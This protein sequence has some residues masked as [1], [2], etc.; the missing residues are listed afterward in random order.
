MTR[1]QLFL[2]GVALGLFALGFAAG[3]FFNGSESGSHSTTSSA[4]QPVSGATTKIDA[5]KNGE[6]AGDRS[7]HVPDARATEE[8]RAQFLTALEEPNTITRL[9]RVMDFFATLDATTWPAAY[10]AM[11][12]ET[13]QTGR[14]HDLE[15]RL[16]LQ[17]GGEVG[18][19]EAMRLLGQKKEG[20][21]ARSLALTG[22]AAV[23]FAAARAW[24]AAL[25]DGPE[26]QKY[27][28]DLVDGAVMRD[29]A[30]AGSLLA[31]LPQDARANF[32]ENLME[33]TIQHG[34]F[35]AATTLLDQIRASA[36]KDDLEYTSGLF[37]TLAERVLRSNW[38]AKTPQAACAW[39]AAHGTAS[40]LQ[41][42][43]LS[44]AAGDWARVDPEGAIGWVD[45]LT[46]RAE[47]NAMTFAVQGVVT[48][49][50]KK[51]APAV[52]TWLNANTGHAQYDRVAWSY[53]QQLVRTDPA[54]AAQWRDTIKDP[55][56]AKSI[57]VILDE[58]K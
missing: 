32:A 4:K 41:P 10:E 19:V 42:D 9:Q 29:P 21:L 43:L 56:L 55:D 11:T 16:M 1:N 35:T 2:P 8:V 47:A 30:Q 53:A 20:Q 52:G 5:G 25:P 37:G 26:K 7:A 54:A 27:F 45:S 57:P 50:G 44:H 31:T 46:G 58:G 23:D 15:W 13:V 24:V 3:S 18:G 40:D 14:T 36:A 38:L 17:R 28:G 51:D 39:I 34:G 49:W 33:G 6:A 22:W 48:Q 12:I